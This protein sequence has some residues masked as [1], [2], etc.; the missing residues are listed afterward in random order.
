MYESEL[1]HYGVKGMK[2]GVRKEVYKSANRQQKKA[3]R[4]DYYETT[5]GKHHRAIRLGV[6]IGGP[7]GGVIG[8]AI[9][10]KKY[11]SLKQTDIDAG[12]DFVN[13]KSNDTVDKYKKN[14]NG[15]RPKTPEEMEASERKYNEL[16]DKFYANRERL[17]NKIKSAKTQAEKDRYM[18]EMDEIEDEYE[19]QLYLNDMGV[20]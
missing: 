9:A 12:K 4:N 17:G 8:A 6:I 15:M 2:W 5:E 14:K 3:I 16:S 20:W 7:V 1:Y 11:G 19:W 13:K 10:R 18:K